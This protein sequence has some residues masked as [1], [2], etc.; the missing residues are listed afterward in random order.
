[1]FLAT[2]IGVGL[3]FLYDAGWNRSSVYS[4]V[5]SKKSAA[6]SK[7]VVFL[8]VGKYSVLSGF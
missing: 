3:S 1:M 2:V 5:M 4:I 6:A 7:P 8:Y